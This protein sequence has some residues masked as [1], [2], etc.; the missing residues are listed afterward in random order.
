MGDLL[1]TVLL[2][3]LR[4][5]CLA[6][7]PLALASHGPQTESSFCQE[8]TRCCHQRAAPKGWSRQQLWSSSVSLIDASEV[9]GPPSDRSLVALVR[10][11]H[12]GPAPRSGVTWAS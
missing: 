9:R 12:G 2:P 10:S 4:A 6:L 1:R 7:R 8:G 11:L 3:P 5:R